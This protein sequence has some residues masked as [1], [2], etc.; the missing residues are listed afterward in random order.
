MLDE[1]TAV[2]DVY[3][4]GY[5]GAESVGELAVFVSDKQPPEPSRRWR[6]KVEGQMEATN[7]Y[8]ASIN[9]STVRFLGYAPVPPPPQAVQQEAPAVAPDTTPPAEAPDRTPAIRTPNASPDPS[10]EGQQ[11]AAPIVREAPGSSK[12]NSQDVSKPKQ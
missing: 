8:G 4:W 1:E 2:F 6:V 3:Q 10:S 9:V 7:G 12:S 5:D 11:P